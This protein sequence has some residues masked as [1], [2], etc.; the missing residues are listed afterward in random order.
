VTFPAKII[1]TN[2]S[3]FFVMA[4]KN[5]FLRDATGL[6]RELSLLDALYIGVG[7]GENIP[8]GLPLILGL[9]VFFFPSADVLTALLIGFVANMAVAGL[10]GLMGAAMPRT[11]GDYVWT[12]R[13]LGPLVGFANN[14][15]FFIAIIA[16]AIGFVMSQ[17]ALFFLSTTLQFWGTLTS[18][19]TLANIGTMLGNNLALSFGLSTIVLVSMLL[20]SVFG[21]KFVRRILATLT[22]LTVAGTLLTIYLFATTSNQQFISEFNSYHVLLG[23]TY[24][25][26]ISIS[27]QNGWTSVA[28]TLVG[29]FLPLVFTFNLYGGFNFQAF[30][31]GEMKRVSRNLPLSIILALSTGLVMWDGLAYFAFRSIGSQF[32]SAISYLY[33]SNPTAY[34]AA[35]TMPPVMSLFIAIAAANAPLIFWAIFIGFVSA[36]FVFPLAYF[37]VLPRLVFS[38]SFDRIIPSSLADVN[39]RLYTPIKALLLT[40]I[41]ME[42]CTSVYVF[43][44]WIFAFVNWTLIWGFINIPW[45][46]A[47]LLFPFWRKEMFEQAPEFVKKKL[48]GIPLLSVL[49]LIVSL[50]G[51]FSIYFDLLTPAY[52]GPVGVTY[53][54]LTAMPFVAAALIYLAS[55]QYHKARG[56]D[57]SLAF[58]QIPPE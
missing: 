6:V 7:I 51:V 37:Q 20:V 21:L 33:L 55:K 11:G 57:L 15:A 53:L 2:R 3:D 38:W 22:I 31:A 41:L 18:D 12:S 47:A 8:V 54:V 32:F 10:F 1:N 5:V 44:S 49:G 24:D 45:G 27:Q 52:S 36:Y 19:T 23:A 46:V 58:K 50:I 56:I 43:G 16:S 39:E 35:L 9:F 28:P 13:V 26:V 4:S 48:G 40:F 17:F 42:L 30:T 29:S 25:Q 14:F 34:S